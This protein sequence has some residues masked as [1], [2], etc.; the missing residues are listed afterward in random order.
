MEEAVKQKKK[1]LFFGLL[2]GQKDE[3]DEEGSFELSFAG[4]FK[5]MCCVKEKPK[6]ENIQL[7]RIADTLQIVLRRLDVIERCTTQEIKFNDF[8]LFEIRLDGRVL[9]LTKHYSF[10]YFLDFKG[11]C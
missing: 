2:P 5:L 1:G 11:L 6:D 8:Y 10:S 4:L 9:Q 3:K 7:A